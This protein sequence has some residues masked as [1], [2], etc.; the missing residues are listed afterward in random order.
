MRCRS[1]ARSN[2]VVGAAVVAWTLRRMCLVQGTEGNRTARRRAE[3][4]EIDPTETSTQFL[5]HVAVVQIEQAAR[6]WVQARCLGS[7][8]IANAGP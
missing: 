5:S 2:F 6:N 4:V 7:M 1:R 3:T 8:D